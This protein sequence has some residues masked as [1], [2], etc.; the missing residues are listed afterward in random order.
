MNRYVFKT[1]FLGTSFC[2]SQKQKN[3]RTVQEELEK[4][5]SIFFR[6]DVT[7]V[8]GSRVD[9]GVHSR[10]M[11]GHFD[12]E[13]GFDADLSIPR[14]EDKVLCNLNGIL[15]LDVSILRISK[16]HDDF[17]SVK[18]AIQRSYLYK[19]RAHSP[20]CPLDEKQVTYYYQA[21]KLNLESLNNV[22]K[23]LLGEHDF[24]GLSNFNGREVYPICKVSQCKWE[25]DS[26]D[27]ELFLLKV[28]AN[29]FLYNMIRV[30]VGTQIA[31]EN[32]K[33]SV[34]SLKNALK[35]RDRSLAGPTA[36]P[37]GLCLEEIKYPFPL[38][39]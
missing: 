29:R 31:I 8:L 16:I 10:G 17:H 25:L 39:D 33:L 37:D 38:F 18:D 9:S 24:S 6:Q 11:I 23:L 3:G 32:G 5:F 15:P 19:L 35:N 1:Q 4:A 30:I 36:K 14:E 26:E 22:S 7:V 2:G 27:K 34:C 28:S 13:D 21:Q 12:L 20:R